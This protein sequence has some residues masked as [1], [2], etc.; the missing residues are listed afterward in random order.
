MWLDLNLFLQRVV[1]SVSVDLWHRRHGM[2]GTNDTMATGKTSRRDGIIHPGKQ[3][4]VPVKLGRRG[5]GKH[6]S[7]MHM[8]NRHEE[9]R[10]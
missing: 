1:A 2:V 7:R 3:A 8:A 10:R 4:S 9:A 5:R 6:R